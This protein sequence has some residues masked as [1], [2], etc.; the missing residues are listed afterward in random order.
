MTTRVA[1]RFDLAH[2]ND[3][4]AVCDL[5]IAMT[6][7][8]LVTG[9]TEFSTSHIAGQVRA[10]LQNPAVG[11][12]LARDEDGQVVGLCMFILSQHLLTGVWGASQVCLYL[13][14]P[15]RNGS[16]RVLLA[17]GRAWA[18]EHGAQ[19]VQ[20]LAPT[21]AYEAFYTRAGLRPVSRVYE[22]AP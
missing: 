7:D 8:S 19:W 4:P 9:V 17:K 11:P 15:W 20:M 5:V 18:R 22:G 12:I 21:P 3:E 6:R 13:A 1:L 10:L 2:P 14:P 16:G